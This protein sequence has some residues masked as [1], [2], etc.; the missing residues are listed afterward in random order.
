[1]HIP[2][3]YSTFPPATLHNKQPVVPQLQGYVNPTDDSIS[4]AIE[5]EHQWLITVTKLLNKDHFEMDDCIS[6]A[7]FHAK[8]QPAK[9]LTKQI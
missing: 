9:T 4:E 2:S 7:A 1:M 3:S 5:K 6:W 8:M